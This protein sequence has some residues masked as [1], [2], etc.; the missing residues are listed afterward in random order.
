MSNV[1][2]PFLQPKWLPPTHVQC[3]L[4]AIKWNCCPRQHFD[5]I[6]I[7]CGRFLSVNLTQIAWQVQYLIFVIGIFAGRMSQLSIL[8]FND[9]YNVESNSTREPIGGAARF[10]TAVKSFNHLNPLVLFSGDAFSP[11][12]RKFWFIRF[13]WY[14]YI[15]LHYEQIQIFDFVCLILYFS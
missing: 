15:L 9:I 14:R 12:M 7:I 10:L 1:W 8:H 6:R 3:K 4:R 13:N 5:V 11:S 2:L